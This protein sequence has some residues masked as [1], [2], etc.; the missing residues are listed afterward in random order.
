MSK[1]SKVQARHVCGGD[2]LE[3]ADGVRRPVM[4]MEV[5]GAI[6]VLITGSGSASERREFHRTAIVT[7]Q[8]TG[9]APQ[10]WR[11]PAAPPPVASAGV[12]RRR[13]WR[14]PAG[15]AA[16]PTALPAQ[17]DDIRADS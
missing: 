1:V 2:I 9:I 17:S 3:C 10:E 6:V 11:G 4:A 14:Q 12:R 7:V 16:T 13:V 5:H 15:R 8:R